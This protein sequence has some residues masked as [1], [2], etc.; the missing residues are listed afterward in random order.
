MK[1]TLCLSILAVLQPLGLAA[2]VEQAVGALS[3]SIDKRQAGCGGLVRI[4]HFHHPI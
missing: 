2:P 1:L 3:Q 4:T